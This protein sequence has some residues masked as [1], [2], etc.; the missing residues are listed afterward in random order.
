MVPPPSKAVSPVPLATFGEDIERRRR[1]AGGVNL[2]RNAGNRR[3]ASK[4]ALLEAVQRLRAE[5]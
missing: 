2:P 4:Q 3:T 1:E 5:W